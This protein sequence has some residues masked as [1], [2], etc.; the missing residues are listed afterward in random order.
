L[1]AFGRT[2]NWRALLRPERWRYMATVA[3]RLARRSI[4]GLKAGG[5]PM[6]EVFLEDFAALA[7]SRARALF[8]FG[9]ADAVYRGFEPVKD[10]LIP[11]L[12]PAIR[13]RI[14]V[15]VWPGPMHGFLEIRRQREAFERVMGWIEALHPGAAT[16]Q[17]RE[18]GDRAWISS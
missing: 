13:S 3:A 17:R 4:P 11:S 18:K 10:T 7:R 15:E 8:L 14:E 6:S 12:D 2:D 1:R 9:D 16:P 5:L